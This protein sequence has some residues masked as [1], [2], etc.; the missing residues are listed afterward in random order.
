L[1]GGFFAVYAT[2]FEPTNFEQV[3][4]NI[5]IP[6]TWTFHYLQGPPN[7]GSGMSSLAISP[8]GNWATI[9]V[10]GQTIP[11]RRTFGGDI[12]MYQS[13]VYDDP[14]G[15][16][17]FQFAANT[18]DSI[19]GT[20]Y[21]GLLSYTWAM[22]LVDI[23]LDFFDAMH[24]MSEGIWDI[25]YEPGDND[26]GPGGSSADFASFA[27]LPTGPLELNYS[28]D[29]DTGALN[30]NDLHLNSGGD[31]FNLERIGE[32]NTFGQ[33]G[34]G[35]ELEMPID[36]DGDILLDFEDQTFTGQFEFNAST[37]NNMEGFLHVT[38]SGGCGATFL[39]DMSY[40]G[41]VPSV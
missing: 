25:A 30:P 39:V 12:S 10:D 27:G 11:F 22:E 8:S 16:V 19:I 28:I 31:Y 2:V 7:A 13:A 1:L 14:I 6:G 40:V 17:S 21:A 32:T 38:G 18:T 36:S 3:N 4:G 33:S 23:D 20:T 35:V 5:P 15:A 29:L 37:G 9:F 26:C 34:P 41:P 24:D